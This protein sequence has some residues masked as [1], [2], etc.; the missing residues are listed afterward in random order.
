MSQRIEVEI[1]GNL[2]AVIERILDN[3]LM[4]VNTLAALEA[5]GLDLTKI[6][7]KEIEMRGN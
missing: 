4:D 5:L 3:G 1:G 7:I 2:R 6:A